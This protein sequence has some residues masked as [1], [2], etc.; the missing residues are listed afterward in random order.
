LAAYGAAWLVAVM[1]LWW[2]LARHQDDAQW[3]NAGV[4]L[5]ELL[6]LG[7]AGVVLPAIALPWPLGLGLAAALF[8]AGVWALLRFD[9]LGQLVRDRYTSRRLRRAV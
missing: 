4:L 3:R 5:A 9:P 2:R 7:T 8:A 1:V 6:A